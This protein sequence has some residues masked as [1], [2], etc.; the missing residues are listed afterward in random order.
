MKKTILIY[1]AFTYIISFILS[2]V[3][4]FT[5]SFKLEALVLAVLSVLF[6]IPLYFIFENKNL[7]KSLT[8]LA[9][10]NLIQAFSIVVFGLTYK[11]IIGPDLSL[12]LINSG[13]KL[14]RFS[15]KIFNIFSYFNY[16][17]NDGTLAL[18]INFIHL[19]MFVYFHFEVKKIKGNASD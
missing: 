17:K 2:V 14:V 8:F 16:V 15:L 10:I 18:G 13:D 1:N 12:Y 4:I 6:L 3:G 19:L 7:K 5:S 11:L 9:R